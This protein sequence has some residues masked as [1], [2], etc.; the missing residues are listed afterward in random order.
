MLRPL[1]LAIA[2]ALPLLLSLPVPVWGQ[3]VAQV[4][5]RPSSGPFSRPAPTSVEPA[6]EPPSL[7]PTAPSSP[8]AQEQ[9]QTAQEQYARGDFSGAL[10]TL[11]L[12]L[13]QQ[14]QPEN[15]AETLNLIGLVQERLNQFELALT[16]YQSALETYAQLKPTQPEVAQRGEA[17]TLNNL[18]TLYASNEQINEALGFMERALGLFRNLGDRESEAITL[19]NLGSLYLRVERGE[20]A[21]EALQASLAIETELER[22]VERVSLLDQLSTLYLTAGAINE[23]LISLQQ[24]YRIVEP[25]N[26]LESKLALLTRIAQ[27]YEGIRRSDK[28]IEHY[29]S[30]LKLVEEFSAELGDARLPLEGRLRSRIASVFAEAGQSGR[31]IAQYEK[32]L[33]IAQ[34][35]DQPLDS[36]ELL[37]RIGDV[38]RRAEDYDPARQSY[39]EALALLEPLEQ[40]ILEGRLLSGLAVIA[41]EQLQWEQAQNY[42][43]KALAAQQKPLEGEAE[44]QL[45]QVGQ[46]VTLNL[47][48]D[49]YQ[50]QSRF[51]QAAAAYQQSLI[52]LGSQGN[53][54]LQGANLANLGAMQLALGE[55]ELAVPP[56]QEAIALWEAVGLESAEGDDRDLVEDSYRLLIQAFLRQE[57]PEAALVA[58][59]QRRS[60]LMRTLLGLKTVA[61][62]PPEP[63]NLR[64][65]QAIAAETDSTLVFYE[66]AASAEETSRRSE[67]LRVWLMSPAGEVTLET[68]TLAPE[69]Q[70]GLQAQQEQPSGRT[71]RAGSALDLEAWSE[72]LLEPI[73]GHLSKVPDRALVMVVPPSLQNLPW[74]A[75]PLERQPLLEQHPLTVVP[76]VL[77]LQDSAS[78]APDSASD[79]SAELK[80]LVIG[81]PATSGPG[82][83]TVSPALSSATSPAVATVADLL[84]VE[85]LTG[86][87]A[88]VRAIANHLPQ[89]NIAH[90]AV[91]QLNVEGV[92]EALA[93]AAENGGQDPRGVT[94][95]DLLT[96]D[97]K[98]DLIVLHGL[99]GNID[100]PQ[101]RELS[102]AQAL[103]AAG[104]AAVVQSLNASDE[105]AGLVLERFYLTLPSGQTTG[106]PLRRAML[107]AR[108]QYP[109]PADWA[110]FTLLG[111]SQP[112]SL[113]A[114][115]PAPA[116]T[117][118]PP[119]TPEAPDR[120]DAPAAPAASEAPATPIPPESADRPGAPDN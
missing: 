62:R 101:T 110:G 73:R 6:V 50:Q 40:P 21:I 91:P 57:Q 45:Q 66:I 64:Q 30:A 80:P 22:P 104:A 11:E 49:L 24:A 52:K 89:A 96:L 55:A 43:Q 106:E 84:G 63:F 27:L 74:A 20:D 37:T 65:I 112:V 42:A 1:A 70:A 99:L 113:P 90:L 85:P 61:N 23:A 67:L 3:S 15:R 115:A 2:P 28:A 31:S 9:I 25:S 87:A 71:N 5:P 77:L 53:V 100:Q 69:Q 10:S 44:Q 54:M 108:S 97:L 114:P 17:R 93:L 19:R 119:A 38:Q 79:A 8:E 35:L 7:S 102:V 117:P 46:A 51:E 39:E 95:G 120:P 92:G 36:V 41:K 81:D 32:A 118:A 78:S 13:Q 103:R 48:G 34:L 109:N 75:L 107:S 82:S 72:L 4:P 47:L 76:T 116:P 12:L 88:T 111:R 86:E 98:A 68:V 16:A 105:A 60:R 26:D 29:Q 18:G 14:K 58:L 94:P 33:A 83:Q 59:E 56:L